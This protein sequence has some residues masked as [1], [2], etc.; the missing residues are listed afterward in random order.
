MSR[1]RFL[2]SRLLAAGIVLVAMSFVIFA[3]IGLMPGDPVA[4]ETMADP[5][6][7]PAGITRLR[8][9][10]GADT[11]LIERYRHWAGA[12]LQG[13]LG[14]SRTQHRP[15]M[16]IVPAALGNTIVL[17]GTAFALA[18]VVAIALGTLAAVHSGSW[19]DRMIALLTYVGISI[20]TFWLGLMLIY[21]FAV[22]LGW[23]PAGGMPQPTEGAGGRIAHFVL[24]VLTLVIVEIGAPTRYVRA[25]MLEV[26][27]QDYVRA[28][29]ARG[30]PRWRVI[31]RHA[32]R[33]AMI[34]VTTIIVLGL[35]HLFSGALL[36]ETIFAWRGMGRLILEAVMDNDYNL[37]LVCLL[38]ITATVLAASILT[39][40]AYSW[41]D[42]R[43]ALDDRRR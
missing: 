16:E 4:L 26:L 10:Y 18:T 1:F 11:P 27:N 38:F 7:T 32:L 2:L 21:L 12:A 28:A 36:T 15:V 17:T 8:Q 42:P 41:L 43:I 14:F 5:D 30:L 6:I 13:E 35:G 22:R 34:P 40:V 9:I 24:P 23:L 29:H 3:L 33:N 20:P 19:L 39:D 37:A 25:A 31:L